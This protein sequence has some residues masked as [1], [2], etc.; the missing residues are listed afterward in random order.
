MT[1]HATFVL[2]W[3]NAKTE[4]PER[5]MTYN[6]IIVAYRHFSGDVACYNVSYSKK[7]DKFNCQDRDVEPE[8]S[9]ENENIVAWAELPTTEFYDVFKGDDN[10]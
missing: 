6:E 4:R 7:H 5:S 3:H 1:D 2:N 8:T 9:F 10:A